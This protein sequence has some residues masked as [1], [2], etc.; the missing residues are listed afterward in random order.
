[1][2]TRKRLRIYLNLPVP[3]ANVLKR[4]VRLECL[5]LEPNSDKI[6]SAVSITLTKL[7]RNG[8]HLKHYVSKIG[9]HQPESDRPPSTKFRIVN[10]FNTTIK[11]LFLAWCSCFSRTQRVQTSVRTLMP[12]SIILPLKQLTTCMMGSNFQIA[13]LLPVQQRFL[14]VYNEPENGWA[15]S[16]SKHG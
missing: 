15:F 10:L 6:K 7:C 16:L 5:F 1:M 2:A 14:S 3:A 8:T 13:N 4:F 11:I 9:Y 12:V